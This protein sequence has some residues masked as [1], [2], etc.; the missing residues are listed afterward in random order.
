RLVHTHDLDLALEVGRDVRVDVGH[1]GPLPARG[2]GVG[3]GQGL[4]AHHPAHA[5]AAHVE[6]LEHGHGGGEDGLVVR[7]DVA[8]VHEVDGVRADLLHRPREGAHDV[9]HGDGGQTGVGEP[10]PEE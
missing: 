3:G 9:V 8:G 10:G 4:V 2:C 1:E 6:G 5:V 7:V